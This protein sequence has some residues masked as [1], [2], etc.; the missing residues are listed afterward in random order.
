MASAVDNNTNLNGESKSARKR[1]SKGSTEANGTASTLPVVPLNHIKENSAA[2]D[3][4]NATDH[5]YLRELQKQIRNIT[6]KLS[7]SQKIDAIIAENPGKSLDSLVADRKLNADQKAAALKKPQLQAQLAQLEEQ[8]AHYRKFDAD[9]QVKFNKQ[10]EDLLATHRD[11]KAVDAAINLIEGSS[12]QVL[13]I[14]GTPTPITYAQVKEASVSHAPFQAEEAWLES[15]EEARGGQPAEE[16]PGANGSDPTI[17]NAGL[18][19]LNAQSTAAAA[20]EQVPTV[21]VTVGETSGNV[22]G[23][24]WDTAAA[25][26]SNESALEE[27]YEII[28][29]PAEEVNDTT[30]AA[31][32]PPQGLNWADE[33]STHDVPTGN[34]AGEA[35]DTRAPGDQTESGA[36]AASGPDDGFHEVPGRNRGRGGFRG[37]G[38]G[39]F[40]GRGGR[41][42]NFRGR[43]DGEFRGGRGGRGAFRGDGEHRGGRGGGRGGPRGGPRGGGD[44]PRGAPAS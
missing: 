29:R 37:R 2:A 12:E 30:G 35:W 42:G 21:Q 41:R 4:E 23:D 24:R 19:E 40:R 20:Q 25:G 44:A 14:E 8:S 32:L 13:S 7:A 36:V 33:P 26:N 5:P 9:Y 16:V 11:E 38:D 39:E 27:S 43:G 17:V 6:K 22:A 31:P 34:Q 3:S 10:R 28:P 18:T 15:V 1:A